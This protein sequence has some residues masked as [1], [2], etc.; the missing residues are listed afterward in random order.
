MPKTFDLPNPADNFD[1][2]AAAD[3]REVINVHSKSFALASR[4]LPKDV[5]PDVCKLYAWCRWCDNAVD[6]APSHAVAKSRLEILRS[7]VEA[8]Y[9]GRT[10]KLMASRWLGDLV[11]RYDLPKH[12]P[13]DLLLGME[14]DLDFIPVADQKDLE[15]YCYRV[16]GVV[17]LMMCRLLGV[18]NTAA[19]ENANRLGIAMQLT[20]IARDIAEDW[21]R[22]RC[23]LPQS[24]IDLDPDS[25]PSP[26][27]AVIQ[28]HA[29]R[30]LD[31]AEANYQS[32]YRGYASLPPGTRLAIRVAAAVYRDIGI[33]IEKS[34]Y[35]VMN[36]RHYVPLPRK[37]ALVSQELC[38]EMRDRFTNVFPPINRIDSWD[39]STQT[40]FTL[41][42]NT[43]NS[44][45]NFLAIF[46]LSMTLIMATVLF[47]LMG[48]NPKLD[49]YAASPWIYCGG[50]AVTAAALWFWAQSIG[51]KLDAMNTPEN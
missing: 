43:M 45:F 31:L 12:L 20:N 10:P 3:E 28:P 47:A 44:Q 41:T 33:E 38:A 18:T 22:G 46:G 36:K 23:Y 21:Q 26:S 40:F 13:L 4:L 25:E 9:D 34:D 50:C 27:D 29:K 17:G 37:L 19:Y 5:R 6:E 8:I 24:W 1:F 11:G 39:L 2:D 30:L 15:L 51:K 42:R 48:I 49:T 14:S 7:D 16:A 35:K 32:G